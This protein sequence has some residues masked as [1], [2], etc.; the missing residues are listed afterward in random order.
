MVTLDRLNKVIGRLMTALRKAKGF[1]RDCYSE[2]L[3]WLNRARVAL[4]KGYEATLAFNL[5]TA[6]YYMRLA[7]VA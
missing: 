2:A 7:A 5:Q 3:A 4:R 1:K 6:D